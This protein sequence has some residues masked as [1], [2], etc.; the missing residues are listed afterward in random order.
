MDFF[1]I[2]VDD[3][4]RMTWLFL[5]KERSE[6]PRIFS[7]F[8]NEIFAQFNKHIKILRSDNALEYTQPV[9]DSFCADRGIIHQTSCPR[10]SQQNGVAERKYRH[11]LDIARTL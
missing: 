1:I 5:M 7:K 11:L 3:Y 2:F 8:Y 4:S 9:V 10:T 6:L